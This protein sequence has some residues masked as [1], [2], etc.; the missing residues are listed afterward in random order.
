MDDEYRPNP[1]ELLEKIQKEEQKKSKGKLKIFFGMCAGVGKTYSMLKAAQQVRIE[2]IDVVVGYIETHGRSETIQLLEGLEI[3]PRQIIH[4]KGIELEEMDINAILKRKPKIVL[5]D[6]LA[7]T[8]VVGSR[9]IKRYQ[10]VLELIDNGIDVYT[11][12]NVQHLE[13]RAETVQEITG[14]KIAETVPDSILENSEEIELI[15][16]SPDDLL[17]RLSEGKVYIADKAVTAAANFFR[18]GNLIALR[19]LSLRLTAERVD[20]D[21]L[22]YMRAKNIVTTWKTTEKLMVAVGPS[23]S[24][25][26]LIRWTRRMA[27]NLGAQWIAVTIDNGNVISDKKRKI[28]S[29]NLDLAIELGA[30]IVHIIDN[31]IISGLLRAAKDNNV[32]QIIIGKTR[33]SNL[34]NFLNGGSIV[35]KL[36]SQS[37]NIDIYVV[38]A[39]KEAVLPRKLSLIF[40]SSSP[41]KDYFK[42]FLAIIAVA[43]I[44]FPLKEIIGYQ[45]V[46]MFFL[47]TVAGI[48]LFWGRG[49]VFFAA[50]LSSLTWNFMFIPPLYTFH[51]NNIQDV[52]VLFANFFIAIVVSTLINRTRKKQA[53]LEKSQENIST[54]F[55]FLEAMNNAS[56]IKDCVSKIRTE[57]KIHFNADAIVYLR[58]KGSPTLAS[59][60]FG[61]LDFFSDKEFAVAN[62]VFENK[63]PAGQF[64]NTLPFASLQ[65]F[66]LLASHG[67]IGVLGVK[68]QKDL[69]SSLDI[70][71]LLNSFINQITSTLNREIS[72]DIAKQ[73]QIYLASQNL[74]QTILNSISHELRTPI[75]I[76]VGASD[77]L[78]NNNAIISVENKNKL[79]SEISI[80][81]FRL[82]H[83]VDNLLNMQRLESGLLKV[84]LDWC[85]INELI[86]QAINRLQN[87]LSDHQILVDI[88]PD[89]PLV[90]LDFGLIE[91]SIF[92][93]LDNAVLYTPPNTVI[94]ISALYIKGFIT[95]TISDEGKGF[96]KTE[97]ERLF[98]KFYRANITKS[99]G[100]GLG[101]SI[102]K[103]FIEAHDG[104]LSVEDNFPKGSSF[105]MQIP[106]EI[107]DIDK[108]LSFLEN[109]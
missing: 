81:A 75:S 28:L 63:K 37:G 53:I 84:K 51:I 99:G 58:E 90:K 92:N 29:S 68:F 97:K 34:T 7:H 47:L 30:K 109:V 67:I 31:D 91:Q 2:G 102:S 60:A 6:E 21:M 3:V 35:D 13:S 36:I 20:M 79:V 39:D 108:G 103:G 74:F 105:I 55:S 49:P 45:T 80:A 70:S 27:F 52:I 8:N 5:V 71:V 44:F 42:A 89:F 83:L 11:T 72:V 4:Y 18:K 107:L 82:N 17:K 33:E 10:D 85:E 41:F 59:K 48:S 19:E 66:P 15:D 14:I 93:I 96:S 38:K 12:I 88:K 94:R 23:P 16:I 26:K 87:E 78:M 86:N 65:Y 106:V 77:N 64:T 25:E 95:I 46:G 32:S 104:T 50:L 56:S 100:T 1:D 57:L 54:V 101:L 40:P 69:K 98:T 9:H 73:N 62:W 22:D 43:G 24:S 76:I 61:N